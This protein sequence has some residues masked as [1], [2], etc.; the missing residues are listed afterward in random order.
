MGNLVSLAEVKTH[1]DI[2]SDD[3]SKDARLNQLIPQ[4]SDIV[5]D[6]CRDD[7]EQKEHDPEWFD[8]G[9]EAIWVRHRP[10]KSI[11]Y[12]KFDGQTLIENTDFLVYYPI[13]KIVPYTA[14]WRR[15]PTFRWAGDKKV[16]EVK[17]IGGHNG[18]P[19]AVKF[20]CLEWL[21]VLSGLKKKTYTTNDGVEATVTLTTIPT[22]IRNI[23]YAHRRVRL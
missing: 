5:S 19:S 4:V 17:Y 2:P 6:Y 15:Y 3:E 12:L 7:F 8:G 1:L 11:I 21:A 22:D 20:G 10:I 23:L 18:A 13:G 16:I 9:S 14:I